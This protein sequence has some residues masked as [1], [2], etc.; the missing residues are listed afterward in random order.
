MTEAQSQPA[1]KP[2][3]WFHP[4]PGRLVLLLLAIECLLWLS[5]RFGWLGWHKGYAVLTAVTVVG[6]AMVVMLVWF[7]VAL[8]LGLRFQFSIRS[9][10]VLVVVVAL[11]CSWMAVEMKRAR[12]QVETVSAIEAIGGGVNY[13]FDSVGRDPPDPA[14]LRRLLGRDFFA[15]VVSA[16]FSGATHFPIPAGT[17]HETWIKVDV[18]MGEF[19]PVTDDTIE[20]LLNGVDRLRELDLTYSGISDAGLEHVGT[21]SYL[22]YL[23]LEQTSITDAGLKRLRN[24]TQLRMLEVSGAKISD[25]GVAKLQQAL[26]HCKITRWRS[27]RRSSTPV[28]R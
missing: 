24:M 17:Q 16:D 4:T 25:A 20:Q 10:L 23:N 15:D 11:P 5:E 14:W 1:P 22:E 7:G 3:R 8:F 2:I 18:V 12:R 19:G 27:H 28:D 6:V 9:L 13:D 21:L 26:P